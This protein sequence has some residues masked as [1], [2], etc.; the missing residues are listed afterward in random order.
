MH[1]AHL[2]IAMF[3]IGVTLV[4]GYEIEKDVRMEIG[5]KVTLKDYSFK[6]NGTEPKDGPNYSATLGKIEVFKN[7]K[8][9]SELMPE[10]RV[11]IASGMPMTEAAVDMGFFRDLY[12]AMGEPLENGAWI[13]RAYYKPFV[14]W[15]FLG[16]VLMALGGMLSVSDRRYRLAIK[17]R[18]KRSHK[19]AT[20]PVVSDT[21]KIPTEEVVIN[22]TVLP[23]GGGKA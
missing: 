22:S 23:E 6:F 21:A 17:K 5:D 12:V 15:I 19:M 1:C 13:V 9:I 11:Y 14:N 16:C 3:V 18:K 7:D 2:G 10:K 4:N 20:E 8:K